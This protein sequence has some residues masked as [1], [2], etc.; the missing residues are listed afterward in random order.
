MKSNTSSSQNVGL[1]VDTTGIN[2]VV[3]TSW[4]RFTLTATVGT[5]Q[6]QILLFDSIV[7]NDETADISI[8]G[9]QLEVGSYASSY[10]P[11]VAASATRI[12]DAC[13]KTGI[14]SLFGSSYTLS[15]SFI[16][17]GIIN[18][19]LLSV[20]IPSGGN[21]DNFI[22]IFQNGS[23][24]LTATGNDGSSVAQFTIASGSYTVGQTFKFAL[25]CQANNVA[26]YINGTQIG[27]DVIATIPAVTA[28]FVGN[29]TD[30]IERSLV[31]QVVVFNVPLTNSELATLTTI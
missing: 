8:W 24:G 21:Y 16:N 14:G 5:P 9:A 22:T 27:T 12:A 29:Y 17:Q 28:L 30:I 11:T 6:A 19:R 23:N 7:G 1:R 4:Q 15:G 2:N 18:T 10:I 3:T 25:R 20:K 26:F 31:N 13:S